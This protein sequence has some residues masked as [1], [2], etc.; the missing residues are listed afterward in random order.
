MSQEDI[1]NI[2]KK[3]NES[4][5]WVQD[6]AGGVERGMSHG[7]DQAATGVRE[8]LSFGLNQASLART[9][10]QVCS[11][12]SSAE[13][14]RREF[15]RHSRSAGSFSHLLGCWSKTGWPVCYR[16]SVRQRGSSGARWSTRCWGLFATTPG[17]A[18]AGQRSIRTQ[19]TLWRLWASFFSPGLE[20]SCTETCLAR[21]KV[22]CARK[23][24]ANTLARPAHDRALPHSAYTRPT[25]DLKRSS[26]HN[27][28]LESILSM[29]GAARS[30]STVACR[31]RTRFA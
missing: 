6:Q 11:C 8:A 28:Y 21:F 18:S 15:C 13:F 9:Q 29:S 4:M 12:L 24:V 27:M 25:R 2:K 16:S 26:V 23:I 5:E 22:R 30:R 17:M 20:H 1:D 31:G 10:A 14:C 3:L 19:H 7:L